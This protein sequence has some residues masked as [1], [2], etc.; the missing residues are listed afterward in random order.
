MNYVRS[1][2]F[3]LSSWII[4]FFDSIN[5]DS[6]CVWFNHGLWIKQS[7]RWI[8]PFWFNKFCLIQSNRFNH[9]WIKHQSASLPDS[10][11][12]TT[13][14]SISSEIDIC[15]YRLGKIRLQ[16]TSLT[17]ETHLIFIWKALLTV[18]ERCMKW[19]LLL[20]QPN[21]MHVFQSTVF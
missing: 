15:N 7:W 21:G 10:I 11:C 3:F 16:L 17:A 9:R 14:L 1:L 20:H 4:N 13:L 19:F 5:P 12:S 2:Q 6:Q 18:H 8:K